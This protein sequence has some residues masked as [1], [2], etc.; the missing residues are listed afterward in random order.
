M[1]QSVIVQVLFFCTKMLMLAVATFRLCVLRNI[2][3][4][5]GSSMCGAKR[6]IPFEET[7]SMVSPLPIFVAKFCQV[8]MIFAVSIFHPTGT[9][10]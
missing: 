9:T 7:T 5:F 4:L 2:S 10:P 1:F 3:R 8:E 6:I